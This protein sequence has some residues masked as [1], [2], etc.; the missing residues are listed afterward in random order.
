MRQYSSS[1]IMKLLILSLI[2]FWSSSKPAFGESLYDLENAYNEAL[3][4]EARDWGNKEYWEVDSSS[5]RAIAM[6]EW[7]GSCIVEYIGNSDDAWTHTS[8]N[9]FLV[10]AYSVEN[11]NQYYA[12]IDG[13]LFSK[14]MSILYRYPAMKQGWYYQV[15]STVE[16]IE[17]EAFLGAYYLK[18]LVIPDSVT[19]IK[20]GVVFHEAC[21]ER[22]HFPSSVVSEFDID[23]IVNCPYLREIILPEQSPITESIKKVNEDFYEDCLLLFY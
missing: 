22:I 9:I 7:D 5:E 13:V 8:G 16:V 18:E 20:N 14:D 21:I 19:E 6:K 15:P 1:L 12:V 10:S 2:L 23:N 3:I 4:V 17:C 11:G